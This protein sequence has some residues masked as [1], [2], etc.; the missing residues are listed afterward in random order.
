MQTDHNSISITNMLG[1]LIFTPSLHYFIPI[2]YTYIMLI[3][4]IYAR[5]H[6][7]LSSCIDNF[8]THIPNKVIPLYNFSTWIYTVGL[9]SK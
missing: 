1:G 2:V 7:M 6:L 3:E 5:I 9:R 8:T 4:G